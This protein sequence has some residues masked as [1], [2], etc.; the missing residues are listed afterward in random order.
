MR[1]EPTLRHT[2][3]MPA[4]RACLVILAAIL[5]LAACGP[6]PAADP[7]AASGTSDAGAATMEFR[8]QR[9]CVDCEGIDA[10]LQL[11]Q[12]GEVRRY[13]L[14]ERYL[15]A[16]GE[17][18]FEERGDWTAEG[19]LIRLRSDEGGLRVYARSQGHALQAR[20]SDGAPLPAAR[21]D[22]MTAVTFGNGP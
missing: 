17:R 13:T 1:A 7:A 15:G 9:P 11:E 8:G 12:D 10:W 18:R 19:D 5:P 22:V 3:G 4:P 16:G 6:M 14:V 21:D 20:A 2:G